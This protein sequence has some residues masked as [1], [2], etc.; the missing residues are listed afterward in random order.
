MKVVKQSCNSVL[1]PSTNPMKCI[2]LIGRVCYKSE[3]KITDDSCKKFIDMLYKRGHT[4]MLEHYRFIMQIPP[5]VYDAISRFN[6]QYI[7]CTNTDGRCIISF[8]AVGLMNIVRD[9]TITK[10][11][12]SIFDQAQLEQIRDDIIACIVKEYDCKELFGL[13]SNPMQTIACKF[14]DNIP[15]A[16]ETEEEWIAH[17][18]I[19]A[20]FTTDRGVTHEIVRHRNN[21]SF[22]QESTRY[23]NYNKGKFG[24]EIT[25]ID[26]GFE[27]GSIEY[28]SWEYA[29]KV[30]E[31]NYQNM[32]ENLIAPQM[33]RSVLPTCLKAE[34][35]VTAP[36]YEWKHIMN[37][38]YHGKKGTPHPLMQELMTQFK[39]IV[40]DM[41]GMEVFR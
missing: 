18:W 40:D 5:V 16:F 6:P 22:A 11:K 27:K 1:L 41:C 3:D 12:V 25:V 39:C 19:T 24:S 2:E 14:I 15:Q 28:K 29:C 20:Q 37:L 30:A 31:M 34:I 23:C 10:D 38:R 32:I 8:N 13:E 26:Q 17:G 33:A 36:V 21:T 9:S 4:A 35:Y 7:K